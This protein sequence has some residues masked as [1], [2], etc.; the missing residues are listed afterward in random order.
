M[1][2]TT[3]TGNRGFYARI[4]GFRPKNT[5]SKPLKISFI[6][7]T[8]NAEYILQMGLDCHKKF[9]TKA[10]RSCRAHRDGHHSE[11]RPGHRGTWS[12]FFGHSV[13]FIKAKN[14]KTVITPYI[15]Y[16][17]IY[18]PVIWHNCGKSPLLMGKSAVNF[19]SIAMPYYMAKNMA[20]LVWYRAHS[21]HGKMSV[22]WERPPVKPASRLLDHSARDHSDRLAH[23]EPVVQTLSVANLWLD[24]LIDLDMTHN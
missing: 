2:K 17:Y 6:S 21:T 3:T 7:I 13:W 18:P 12:V 5:T 24:W 16:I 10:P 8:I 23:R 14:K 22:W 9:T 11:H 19:H 15:I 4:W 20:G 1:K